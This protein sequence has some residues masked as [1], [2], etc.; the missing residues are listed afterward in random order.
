[1]DIWEWVHDITAELRRNGQ[2]RLADLIRRLP[3]ETVDDHHDRVD[4][5][6]PE[7]LALARA[8]ELPWVEVFVRHWHLQSRILHR[9]QGDMALGEAVALV[10]FSHSEAA[11]GCPQAVCTVQDLTVCYA[12]VDGPGYA[13]ERMAVSRE[14]LSRIDPTWPC[15]TCIS[16]EYAS[17]LRDAG[18]AQAALELLDTQQRALAERGMASERY[19]LLPER[20]AVLI[21][22]GRLDEALAAAHDALANGRRDEGHRRS[23]RIDLARIYARL[24]RLEEAREALPALSEV[25]PT[26]SHYETYTDALVQLVER[27]ERANDSALGEVLQRFI[28]RV[29]AQGSYRQ[30]L[31]LAEVAARL[32]CQRGAPAVAQIHLATMERLAARLRR[33][34]GAPERLAQVRDLVAQSQIRAIPDDSTDREDRLLSLAARRATEPTD[35]TLTRDYAQALVDLGF[36]REA[37]ALLEAFIVEFPDDDSAVYHLAAAYEQS[38]DQ[39]RHEA[40]IERLLRLPED[41]PMRLAG[42]WIAARRLTR[43]GELPAANEHLA[44]LVAARPGAI[45][46]RLLHAA[47]ARKLGEWTLA[48]RL[49][50]DVVAL[51]SPPGSV[52]WD[53]MVAA[54]L[55]GAWGTVRDSATRLGI[56]LEASEGPV[57]ER[58]ELCVVR[59]EHPSGKRQDLYAVRTGPVTAR[60]IQISRVDEP[61]RFGDVVVFDARPL[62]TPPKD[63]ERPIFVYEEVAPLRPAGSRAFWIDG[64]HPGEDAIADL[65]ER[66]GELGGSLQVQ[67]GDKYQVTD[68][69]DGTTRLGVYLFAAFPADADLARASVTLAAATAGLPYPLVW[70]LLARAAGDQALADAHQALAEAWQ[71]V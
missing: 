29:E 60:I 48:L 36:A 26:P 53:R 37:T 69:S 62:N 67:S 68:P 34:C 47:N 2:D 41:D 55:L 46:A 65:R 49:L 51:G 38:G 57:D 13:P 20:I 71:L 43:L 22:L 28:A 63:E 66:L 39:A 17:A 16:T 32:A 11:R 52:D 19:S 3:S 42:R 24:G 6:A 1:M 7:A 4:T 54:T 40:L 33:P 50:D 9:C 5:L 31:L 18:D 44:A 45:N 23:R 12:Q 58:W 70:P 30:P 56:R 8:A 14:T 27:G 21:A 25:Q 59:V 35:S 15:F 64:V 10:D 61:Q